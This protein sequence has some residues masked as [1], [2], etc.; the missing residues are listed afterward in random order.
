MTRTPAEILKQYQHHSN[1]EGRVICLLCRELIAAQERA[2]A[3]EASLTWVRDVSCGE[4]QLEDEAIDDTVALC[5]IFRRSASALR[6]HA[7]AL[8]AIRRESEQIGW[9]QCLN[10]VRSSLESYP[11]AGGDIE[12]MQAVD[13]IRRE[14]KRLVLTDALERLAI[15]KK[16]C[17]K[18]HNTEMLDACVV[19]IEKM[20]NKQETK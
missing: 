6:D 10:S 14:E 17:E 1:G 11:N 15:L 4:I 20:I 9:N 13:A 3:L 18:H 16:F 8:E 7:G 2:A 12:I 5:V 19:V